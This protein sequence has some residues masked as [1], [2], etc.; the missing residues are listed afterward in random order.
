MDGFQGCRNEFLF[1]DEKGSLP[2][3]QGSC[4]NIPPHPHLVGVTLVFGKRDSKAYVNH[5]PIPV[6]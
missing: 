4:P 5:L 2:M 1:S 6:F 3:N